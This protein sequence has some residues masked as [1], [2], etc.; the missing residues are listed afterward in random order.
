MH[1]KGLNKLPDTILMLLSI[2]FERSQQLGRLLVTGKGQISHPSSENSRIS[3]ELEAIN[4]ISLSGSAWS[5]YVQ[6]PF[7]NPGKVI[8][9]IHMGLPRTGPLNCFLSQGEWHY[10]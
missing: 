4:I 9:R 3:R 10:E 5:K 2:I 8:L 1:P 6:K 7:L